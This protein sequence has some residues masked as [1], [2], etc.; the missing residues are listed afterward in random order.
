MLSQKEMRNTKRKQILCFALAI[1]CFCVAI[2]C[3]FLLVEQQHAKNVQ[4]D[5]FSELAPPVETVEHEE[6]AV[7]EE[8]KE[9]NMELL[10]LTHYRELAKENS[11][12]VGWIRI[13]DTTVNYPV[14]QTPD[15]FNYYL[16]RNFQK[17]YSNLGTP[18][19][20]EDCIIGES[21]NIVIYGHHM[22]DGGM[23]SDL[24]LYKEED[25]WREHPMIHFDTLD[26]IAEYEV[27]AVI[28]TTIYQ[29]DSFECH[30]YTNCNALTFEKYVSECL[31]RS[32]YDTGVTAEYG[33]KL[34]TLSTCEYSHEYGRLLVV[35][36]KMGGESA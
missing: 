8:E 26:E 10:L 16:R 6:S 4:H 12:M 2:F 22:L 7:P 25:F 3:G 9:N 18:Y 35:A 15:R 28:V 36:K 24:E 34:I 14:M 27:M 19:A 17:E 29:P 32:L 11:D 21:D 31:S 30:A 33:D 23:F 1:F 5:I 13:D 20:Q